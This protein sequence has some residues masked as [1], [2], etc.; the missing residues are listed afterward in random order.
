M[1]VIAYKT[2]T[3]NILYAQ[4]RRIQCEH[5]RLPFTYVWGKRDNFQAVGVPLLSSDEGM[6]DSAMKQ[7]VNALAGVARDRNKGESLCPNCQRYQRWMVSNSR[8]SKLGCGGLLGLALAGIAAIITA[9][10]LDWG[11]AAILGLVA[12][13]V[14]IGLA[15]GARAAK[16][17][18][19]HPGMSDRSAMKDDEVAPFLQVCQEKGVDPVLFWYVALGNRPGEKEGFVSLGVLDTTDQQPIFPRDLSTEY[20]IHRLSGC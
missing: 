1:P 2:L 12:A 5:C 6:R 9:S 10:S 20:A 11:A 15:L 4:S 14:I 3:L 16:K 13:G 7:A 19:P 8:F 17:V 18:G